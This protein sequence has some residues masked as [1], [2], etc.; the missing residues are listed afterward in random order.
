MH[1]VVNTN[2]HREGGY[3]ALLAQLERQGVEHT[4][5]R[6][7]PFV[8]Y[9]IAIHD[10][11]DEEGHH[12]PIMLDIEGP[13]FVT[14]T[15]S[16]NGVS[17][18]HGWNPGYIDSPDLFECIDVWGDLCLN[19]QAIL[20]PLGSIEAPSDHFFIRPNE[21][22][23]AFAGTVMSGEKFSGWRSDLMSSSG[24]TTLPPETEVVIAPLKTIWAEYRTII[25]DGRYVTGSRYKTGNTVA[26]SPDVGQRIIDFAQQRID[27]W[28]PRLAIT[29]DIADTPDGLKVIETNA[30]SSSGFY[31]IDMNKF[32]GEITALGERV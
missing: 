5:V 21:Y 25:V 30:I 7:P 14:G 29:L 22:S 17:K 12:R 1:W 10:D 18:A 3:A 15:T 9:L 6:K 16:M 31:A 11:L 23:K 26:Y 19:S 8:E 27:E 2:L 24:Y 13:V 20:G 32:V 4:L 28:N